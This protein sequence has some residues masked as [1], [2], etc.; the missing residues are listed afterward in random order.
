MS[1]KETLLSQI[2]RQ[3][4]I[5]TYG[6]ISLIFSGLSFIIIPF[7]LNSENIIQL[8]FS[9]IGVTLIATSLVIFFIELPK[10]NKKS[11]LINAIKEN[12]RNNYIVWM[13]KVIVDSCE[14]K[15]KTTIEINTIDG[16]KY[17]V[18]VPS[19]NCDFLLTRLYKKYDN[20]TFGYNE[21]LEDN[22]KTN[23][24]SLLK[25]IA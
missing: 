18:K 24:N 4:N 22:F 10:Y 17:N 1:T 15:K 8:I 13:Y 19:T 21:S 16:K 12:N 23:P 14:A 9:L 3:N 5:L 20:V 2:K 6:T 7:I 11:K 25:S